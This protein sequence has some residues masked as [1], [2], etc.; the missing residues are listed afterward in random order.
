MLESLLIKEARTQVFSC[1]Y[2]EI[3]KNTY[4]EEHLQAAASVN[5]YVYILGRYMI[6]V[7]DRDQSY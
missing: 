2:C 5:A 4:V 6:K 1:E 7:T 3:F